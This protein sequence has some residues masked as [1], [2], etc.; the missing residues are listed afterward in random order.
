MYKPVYLHANYR[1]LEEREQAKNRA[2]GLQSSMEPRDKV[3]QGVKNIIG[4]M[5]SDKAGQT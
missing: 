1:A 3:D 4:T 5:P 2:S